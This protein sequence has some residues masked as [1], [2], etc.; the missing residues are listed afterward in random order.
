MQTDD[1][2]QPTDTTPLRTPP[3]I[4]SNLKSPI[5]TKETPINTSSHTA[6]ST[7]KLLRVLVFGSRMVRGLAKQMKRDSDITALGNVCGGRTISNA[8][9]GYDNQAENAEVHSVI[10]LAG[11]NNVGD[12]RNNDDAVDNIVFKYRFIVYLLVFCIYVEGR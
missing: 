7:E 12:G 5:S 6:G 1:K 3:L 2:V 11:T 9:S 4:Q 8:V 10:L